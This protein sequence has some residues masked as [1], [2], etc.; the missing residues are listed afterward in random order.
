MFSHEE[1]VTSCYEMREKGISIYD[2]V[3]FKW[4]V[5]VQKED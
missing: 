4:C 1:M 2:S 5:N 3:C